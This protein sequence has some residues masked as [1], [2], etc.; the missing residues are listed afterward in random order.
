MISSLLQFENNDAQKKGKNP[1]KKIKKR[2]HM[3][4]AG[5]EPAIFRSVGGR[6]AIGPAGH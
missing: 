1:K 5:I 3:T 4:Y 2:N 6:L